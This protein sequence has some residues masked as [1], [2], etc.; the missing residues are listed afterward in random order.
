VRERRGEETADSIW[1]GVVDPPR[2]IAREGRWILFESAR[3]SDTGG[4]EG[5]SS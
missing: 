3:R 1:Q 2:R 4:D 5:G